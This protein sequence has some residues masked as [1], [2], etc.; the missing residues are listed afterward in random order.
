M[1]FLF[2]SDISEGMKGRVSLKFSLDIVLVELFLL[3]LC[4]HESCCSRL[5]HLKGPVFMVRKMDAILPEISPSGSPQPFLPLLAPSPLVPFTNATVPK[6]SGL[7]M[8]NFSA[9]E[10]LMSITA[11]DCWSAFAPFLANVICCP[12]LEATLAILIGQ[13]SKDTNVLA[14]NRT[15]AK[16]CLSDI[17]QILIGQGANDSLTQICSV[18]A[19]NLTEASC[20]V[21]HV[22]EF[23]STV[24]TSKLLAACEEIN[25]VK[26]CCSQIC[27]SA[28]LEAA[29]RIALKA[30]EILSMDGSHVL[31]EYSTRVNDCKSIVLRWLASKLD[32]SRSK[33]VLRG[34]SN[35]KVNQV[36]PL[37]FPDMRH[38]A[39]GCGDGISNQ[40]A[41][42]SAMESYVSHL[43]KQ[44]FITNL[45][46]LDCAT[47]LGIKLRKS[48]ITENVYRLC[49]V[50][51][52]DF[53]LQVGSQEAGCLLPSMPS[54]A[55]FDTS[56]G[57][58]FLCDLNDNIPA[59]WPT[60][61]QVP[62]SSCNK[63]VKIPALPA[64][65]SAQSEFCSDDVMHFLLFASSMVFIILL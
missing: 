14:L 41:C 11:I 10:S 44:S 34:L 19:S 7:C 24:D 22:N 18:H 36:C 54:D 42:C 15:L 31:P 56:S 53:S 2:E 37:V 63:T 29:T 32:P 47:S 12:Q 45:Q 60:T 1:V 23:E 13:S 26:E 9:A 25:P 16:P 4:F 55:T 52:K 33:K 27:Q 61:S 3:L 65:A 38:V 40:T 64:A 51:L 62:A 49:H 48:N 43:Q 5:D 58:G 57:V 59:P 50:S 21:K 20:P 6:L 28:I 8:L 17:E 39:R 46:S 30:S 35:C